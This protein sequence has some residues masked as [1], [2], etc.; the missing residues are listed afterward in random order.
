[1]DCA[2]DRAVRQAAARVIS[3]LAARFRDLDLAE[4]AFS[5]ACLAAAHAWPGEGE[6]SDPTGWLYRVAYRR[7]LDDLRRRNVRDRLAPDPPPP[8]PTVEDG[9]ADEARLIP[10][11]RLRLI[12]V[13]CHPAIAPESRAALTLRLV[14][15]LEA[16]E[17]AAAFLIPEATLLQRLT[18]AKRKIAAAGVPFAVP[19]PAEWEERLDAVLSTLEIAYSK[20]HEDA[21]AVG[22]HAGFADEVLQLTDSLAAM[23]PNEGEVLALA[24]LVRYAEARRPSRLDGAGV[25]VPLSEQDPALWRRP[26]VE[27]GD[28]FLYRARN[29]G[30]PGPRALLAAIHGVW[31]ARRNLRDPPPWPIVLELYDAMLAQRDD[32]IVRL[33]RAVALAEV[34]SADAALAEVEALAAPQLEAFQPWHAVRADLLRRVGRL[35]ES[36]DAYQRAIELAPGPGERA[37]LAARRP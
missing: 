13:C 1:M 11:E 28:R 7:A 5:E 21:A 22:P 29:L 24:A 17:I 18:R 8:E 15:G 20:A 27:A 19:G 3:A 2:L 31:C 14:C 30:Q 37:W 26:L 16:R 4:D 35:E 33:N 32:V 10:D 9:L 34:K 25:M 23:L 12:F 6:P 36:R